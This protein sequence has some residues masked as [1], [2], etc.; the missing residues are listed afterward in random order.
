MSMSSAGQ[1]K[2]TNPTGTG[3]N[4]E[5]IATLRGFAALLVFVA[6]LP[7][8]FPDIVGFAIGRTGVAIFFL[9]TGYL[10][11]QSRRKRSR[12][13]LVPEVP[14]LCLRSVFASGGEG[15]RETG[16]G[17]PPLNPFIPPA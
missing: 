11:V 15:W 17:H 1:K 13:C 16:T 10:A 6:H 14:S 9:I 5:W 7:I 3:K 4:Y 2:T 8:P 12:G